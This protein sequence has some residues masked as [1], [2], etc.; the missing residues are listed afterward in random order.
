MSELEQLPRR[1]AIN[2]L[3]G[4]IVHSDERTRWRA[5]KAGGILIGKFADEDPEAARVMVRRLLWNLTEESGTCHWGATE[6]IGEALSRHS[7]LAREFAHM[8]V[9]FIVP[10]GNHLEHKPLLRGAVWGIAR[11]AEVDP[12]KIRDAE[13]FLRDMVESGDPETGAFAAR[14]LA[15]MDAE[16]TG[17][18]SGL[19]SGAPDTVLVFR[20]GGLERRPL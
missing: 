16:S 12:E 8:L 5:I 13:P 1:S 6:L 3:L 15:L 20:D 17:R 18:D 7:G 10:W 4:R 2:A 19:N 14:A 11:L 9:S